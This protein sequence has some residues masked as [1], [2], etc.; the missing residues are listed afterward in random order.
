MSRI[1]TLL[2]ET[3]GRVYLLLVLV[4]LNGVVA[5]GCK[6]EIGGDELSALMKQLV[7]GVLGI[8]GWLSE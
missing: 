3:Y 8:G 5:L 2:E 6:N 7:E 1:S 4:V